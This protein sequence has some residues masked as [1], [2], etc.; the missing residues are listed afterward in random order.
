[1]REFSQKFA[2]FDLKTAALIRAHLQPRN[3]NPESQKWRF[4]FTS[5]LKPLPFLFKYAIFRH[6]TVEKS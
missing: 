6:I 3:S 2:Q 5:H 4:F 1:L